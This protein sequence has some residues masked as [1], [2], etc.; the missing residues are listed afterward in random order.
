[1]V[2]RIN[3]DEGFHGYGE[4]ALAFT[5]GAS[6]AFQMVRELAPLIIGMDP[7]EHEVVWAKLFHAGFWTKGNGAVEMGAISALDMALWDIK[8]KA[9]HQPLYK[10]L[11]GKQRVKLRTYASQVQFGWG[12]STDNLNNPHAFVD[13]CKAALAE[14]YD[15]VKL[16]FLLQR[17]DGTWTS[18]HDT[19]VRLTRE[20]MKMAEE[21]VATVRELIG[22]DCDLILENHAITDVPTAVQFGRMCE[23]YRIFYYEE[24]I[25]PLDP[26]LMKRVADEVDIPLASGE[27]LYTRWGFKPFLENG[28]LKIMQPDLGTCGGVT[29]GKKI[30]DMAATYDVSVQTHVCSSPITKAAS[31]HL[32]AALPNFL[33][34]EHHGINTH[35]LNVKTCV[36]DYQPKNGW[37]EIPELPGIGQ[38]LSEYAL[39]YADTVTVE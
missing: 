1:V 19:T 15:C 2:C 16:N 21:R 32:E 36:H 24:A 27:R 18:Y 10:L 39:K 25:T 23:R 29:E 14:G 6:A 31:L 33:I 8:G 3:T 38:E 9:A 12:K 17:R 20:V 28:S 5:F 26:G 7:L 35:P 13:G 4:S 34:H 37:Y 30:C 22:D 11:G